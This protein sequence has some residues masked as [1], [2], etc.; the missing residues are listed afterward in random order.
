MA[1]FQKELGAPVVLMGFGLD[2]TED[3]ASP[4]IFE[5]L[6]TL[7]REQSLIRIEA[8]IDRLAGVPAD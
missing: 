1:T 3:L 2:D 4:G 8:A 6:A 5:S 7:G